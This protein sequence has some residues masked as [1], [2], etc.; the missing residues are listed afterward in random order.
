MTASFLLSLLLTCISISAGIAIIPWVTPVFMGIVMGISD[1]PRNSVAIKILGIF[2]C[3]AVLLFPMFL[4]VGVP[5]LL[6]M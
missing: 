1:D 4:I 6:F 3:L 5:I 2:F